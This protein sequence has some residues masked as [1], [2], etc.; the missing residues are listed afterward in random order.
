MERGPHAR[1]SVGL[2]LLTLLTACSRGDGETSPPP[3]SSERRLAEAQEQREF[4]A[5]YARCLTDGGFPSEVLPDGGVRTDTGTGEQAEAFAELDTRCK[6]E[7]G[8]APQPDVYTG[9][10]LS[11][12][13]DLQVDG[14]DC[15]VEAGF[16]P[17]PPPSR[18]KYVADYEDHQVGGRSIPWSPWATM[19]DDRAFT[20]CPQMSLHD[21]YEAEDLK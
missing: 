8:A 16:D 11:T 12:L 2:A 7:L 21:Y 6:E 3:L 20:A 14:Y 9:V 4:M 1:I 17:L 19:I 5:A 18:E 13:Y 10:E 15:L